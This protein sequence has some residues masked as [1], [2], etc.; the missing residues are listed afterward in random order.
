MLWG[1]CLTV[2]GFKKK[3]PLAKKV[4]A[5]YPVVEKSS[6]KKEERRT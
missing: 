4:Q 1:C 3:R 5:K 2:L 6:E